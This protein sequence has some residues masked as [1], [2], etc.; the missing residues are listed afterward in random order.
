MYEFP[1]LMLNE[2]EGIDYLIDSLIA[3][4]DLSQSGSLNCYKYEGKP[5]YKCYWWDE[6]M[7]RVEYLGTPTDERVIAFK[8]N[9]FNIERLKVLKHDRALLKKIQKKYQDYSPSA[10]HAKLPKSYQNLPQ[11][12]YEDERFD[13]MQDWAKEKYYKNPYLMPDGATTTCDGTQVRSKGECIW[14]DSLKRAGI[15]FRYDPM[16]KLRDTN[17][18]V[19]RK[20][21]DFEILCLSGKLF[22]IEHLGMLLNQG[23]MEDFKEKVRLYMLN[24]IVI[25][26]NLLLTSDS[27]DGGINSQMITEL[28]DK[29][30]KP[31]VFG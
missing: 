14:Y 1:E 27:K 19:K 28:I 6:G 24:G 9:R 29:I 10:I 16:I 26:D 17:G 13:K 23:Y 7:R 20:S 5:Y 3:I 12:C 30:I 31:L 11:E 18:Y 8:R 21:P 22:Y 4:T 25:G 15:P 2:I